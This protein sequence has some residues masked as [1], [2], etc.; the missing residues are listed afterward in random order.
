MYRFARWLAA[1]SSGTLTLFIPMLTE[2]QLSS[3]AFLIAAGHHAASLACG[4]VVLYCEYAVPADML[5]DLTRYHNEL[6]DGSTEREETNTETYGLPLIATPSTGARFRV[7][8]EGDGV[9]VMEEP[10][11]W[12]SYAY[13]GQIVFFAL[14]YLFLMGYLLGLYL[15]A[16]LL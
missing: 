4:L 5:R 11:A 7:V 12:L 1:L 3:G 14:G 10:P 13:T 2:G 9:G 8:L 16:I 6:V 15:G